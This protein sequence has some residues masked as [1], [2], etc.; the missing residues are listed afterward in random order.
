[1]LGLEVHEFKKYTILQTV[2]DSV[3]HRTVSNSTTYCII[4]MLSVMPYITALTQKITKDVSR[5]VIPNR[6]AVK[7]YQGCREEVQRVP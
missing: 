2:K 1:M 4:L 6:G 7:R 5:A 3:P